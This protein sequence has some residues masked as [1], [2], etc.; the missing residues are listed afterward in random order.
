MTSDHQSPN[1][2]SSSEGAEIV[3]R[4]PAISPRLHLI[5]ADYACAAGSRMQKV[6]ISNRHHRSSHAHR[7]VCV[8][9]RVKIL[10]IRD[11]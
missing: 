11:C 9:V 5:Y 4:L 8:C 2:T 7:S 1:L 10:K 3:E 6:R